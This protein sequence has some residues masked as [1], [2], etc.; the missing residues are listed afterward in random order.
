MRHFK[1]KILVSLVFL[2]MAL[3]EAQAS[4]SS[5]L[6]RYQAGK[7]ESALR[8]YKRLLIDKPDDPRLHFNAG[9]AAFR[10]N[11]FEEAR[12]QLNSA[13]VTQDLPL[14][15]RTYYNL[16]NTEY[17]LGAE[18]QTPDKKQASWEQA[19]ANYESALKLDPKDQDA[20]YNLEFVKKK[21]EELQKE[22]QKQKDQQSK[23]DQNKDKQDDQK[24]QK[25]QKDKKD[26]Q[27]KDDQK[28][29]EEK[30]E[31]EKQKQKQ[32]QKE[33]E[34]K[35]REQEQ[36]QQ[37]KDGEDKKQNETK[38]GEEAKDQGKPDDQQAQA[39]KGM[40]AQMTPQQAQQ[41]LDAQ[42]GEEKPLIFIPKL[43]TNRMDRVFKDW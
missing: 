18:E 7:Y 1:T 38:K 2:L 34:D 10:V 4:S 26:Q 13:L 15:E 25:D 36:A 20:R 41:L 33:Q 21:L 28:K 5:A 32:D 37:K 40:M 3:P 16:G 35:K 17:Q 39:K 6:K 42:K 30:S 8:E 27:S 23:D 31:Q 29:Q 14:Q 24:D 43:K 12:K 19:V 9:A 11:D 22:Q